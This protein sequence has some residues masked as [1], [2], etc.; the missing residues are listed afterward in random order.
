MILISHRNSSGIRFSEA[1]D[2][3][4]ASGGDH[5][6]PSVQIP[7]FERASGVRAILYLIKDNQCMIRDK[8]G[9]SND[10]RN[11]HYHHINVKI[12][13]ESTMHLYISPE[14]QIYCALIIR[15]SEFPDYIGFSRL[16]QAF[17]YKR[18]MFFFFP[19]N[20]PV[21][22]IPFQHKILLPASKDTICFDIFQRISAVLFVIFKKIYPAC[23]T[24]F[25]SLK[26]HRF[27][28]RKAGL[29]E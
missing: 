17:Y 13:A 10:G 15:F 23:S 19:G 4:K 29:S 26:F 21:P 7:V 2:S 5:I 16:P 27:L 12:A 1:F 25:Q 24:I 8:P 22:N 28:S 18:V 11:S 20:Q 6:I 3:Q 14:I 9:I